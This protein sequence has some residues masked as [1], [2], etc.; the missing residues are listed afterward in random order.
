MPRK[1]KRTE[2]KSKN[3]F[4]KRRYNK[5]KSPAFADASKI[6]RPEKKVVDLNS[7][8]ACPI[9]SAFV[10]T[11]ANLNALA[12]GATASSRIGARIRMKSVQI[13]ANILWQGGQTLN[14]PAQVRFVVV[15]DKQANGAVATRSDVFADGTYSISPGRNS[16]DERFVTLIDEVSD[17][18]ANGQ[19]SVNWSA[20][21]KMELDAMYAGSGATIASTGA[22]LLFAAAMGD[23]NDSTATHFPEIEFYSRVRYTDE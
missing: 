5:N 7:T 14:A 1:S 18:L 20:Y 9:G 12:D 2:T 3:S 15:Y 23:S 13:R 16:N 17:P 6:C 19:F 22:L 4:K 11:P 21:R 8:L 10:V